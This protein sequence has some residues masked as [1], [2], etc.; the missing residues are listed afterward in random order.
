MKETYLRDIHMV[1]FMGLGE[2]LSMVPEKRGGVHKDDCEVS[3]SG[4]LVCNDSIIQNR[5][6]M[7][8]SRFVEDCI[9]FEIK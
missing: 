5:K 8:N 4:I 1:D 6:F 9:L 7:R 3:D 2:W